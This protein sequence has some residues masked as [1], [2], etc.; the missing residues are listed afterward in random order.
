[1]RLNF[2][3]SNGHYVAWRVAS[4]IVTGLLAASVFITFFFVYQ[5]IM[6][7]TA[8]SNIIIVLGPDSNIENLDL[9]GYQKTQTIISAKQQIFAFPNQ[10]RYLFNFATT[11]SAT[12]TSTYASTTK[13]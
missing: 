1:M 4:I 2:L 10:T 7:T 8:N 9:A 5:N 13:K 6:A 3:K 12:I 11:S